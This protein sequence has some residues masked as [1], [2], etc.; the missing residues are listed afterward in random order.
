MIRSRPLSLIAVLLA[1]LIPLAACG[2][3]DDGATGTA[4]A[5]AQRAEVLLD[6]FPNADHAGLIAARERGFFAEQGVTVTTSV[7]SD[8]AAALTQVAAGRSPFALSY[9]PE[10]LLARA[11]GIPVR[12]VGAV[13]A[14]PLNAVIAREDRGIRRPRDL[15]GRTVGIA[16]VPSDRPLLDAVVRADGGDP[17][18]VRTRTVGYTLAP[19]LV[20]GRVDAIIGAYW[21][22]EVPEIESK[23]VGTVVLRLEEHGVPRYDEL[24][25]VT[26]DRVAE[27]RPELVR[28]VLSGLARGQ[29]WAA[30]NPDEATDL[31]A[32]ANP[33]L[34]RA[35]L[36]EQVRLTAPLLSRDLRL[37]RD[38]WRTYADW[39]RRNELLR[40]EVDVAAAADPSFLPEG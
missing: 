38:E 3:D 35:V 24:V 19:A 17:A 6:W 36:P 13:F 32:A 4:T 15:E 5:P 9:Q 23:G 34:S 37:G 39:M 22:I 28:A 11:R 1:L 7:P 26:S 20:A 16:G 30:D 31:V 10:V 21:N 8:P 12:A 25:L 27:E 29:A 40:G 33:D 18:R 14:Q 2:G